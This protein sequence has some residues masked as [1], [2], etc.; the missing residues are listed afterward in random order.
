[1]APRNAPPEPFYHLCRSCGRT[2]FAPRA[3]I[4]CPRCG[5]ECT[6]RERRRPPWAPAEA[7]PNDPGMNEKGDGDVARTDK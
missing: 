1:M 7:G 6:S 4:A 5:G 3:T 2:F